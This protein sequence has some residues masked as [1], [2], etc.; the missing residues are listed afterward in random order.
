MR[1]IVY[2]ASASMLSF[3]ALVNGVW[4]QDESFG[5]KFLGSPLLI[6][7]ILIIVDLIA[8]VFHKIRR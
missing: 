2:L 4:A 1:K 5:D 7:T 3:L 6:L 8:M